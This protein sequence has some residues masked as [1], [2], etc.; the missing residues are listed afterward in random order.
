MPTGGAHASR[1]TRTTEEKKRENSF[2]HLNRG[3]N[4]MR[5]LSFFF[6]Q[7]IFETYTRV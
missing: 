7:K 2:K 1:F 4:D 6:F 5:M 3:K